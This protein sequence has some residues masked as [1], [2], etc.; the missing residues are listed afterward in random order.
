MSTDEST[1]A[2]GQTLAQE[3]LH[4]LEEQIPALGLPRLI[5]V[6]HLQGILG[7]A[8]NRTKD[9]HRVQMQSLGLKP[10]ELAKGDDMGISVAGDTTVNITV[11]PAEA[12]KPLSEPVKSTSEP[13]MLRKAWPLAL[14]AMGGIGTVGLPAA[15]YMAAKWME[16]HTTV[17]APQSSYDSE[18]EVLFFD[19]D[20]KPIEVP[21]ISTRKASE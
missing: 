11:P 18:Y 15:G 3:A 4:R 20:G 12:P 16:Q 2:S 17:V 8:R 19:K 21:H 6:D 1:N 7:D 14:A 10:E 5:A 9:S 13:S